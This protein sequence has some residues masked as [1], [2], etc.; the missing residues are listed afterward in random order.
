MKY[1]HIFIVTYG[2]S[3]STLLQGILNAIPGV[4]IRSENGNA[5]YHLYSAYQQLKEVVPKRKRATGPVYP[6]FGTGS[7]DVEAYGQALADAFREHVLRPA[8]D[9][10]CVGFKE[11]RYGENHVP[12]L[13]SY[14]D[15]ILSKFARS[16]LVFNSRDLPATAKSKWWAEKPDSLDYL[17]RCEQR[18]RDYH[19]CHPDNTAWV[20]YDD[21]VHDCHHLRQLFEFLGAPFDED[22]VKTVLRRRHSF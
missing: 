15:F 9:T 20:R 18:M 10:E 7:I 5:L 3:G 17:R 1:A 19:D 16:C 2:R 21:Y 12:E 4:L 14:L 6:W 11:I 8:D 22:I 13:E